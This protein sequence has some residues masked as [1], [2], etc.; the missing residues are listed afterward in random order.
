MN[1]FEVREIATSD[2]L[3]MILEK[4]YAQRKPSISYAFGLFN[5]DEM[6]GVCTFGKPASNSL[7]EGVCG[8]ENKE[9]VFELNRLYIDVNTKNIASYFVSRCL[10]HLKKFRL[11]IVS[12]SDTGMS[13]HGYVYQ[14]T[15]FI[16]TGATKE[17]TDMYTEGNKHS[18]HYGEENKHLRKVRTSK[19]IYVY[20]TDK[21]DKQYLKYKVLPYPKGDNRNYTPGDRQKTKVIN[22]DNNSYYYV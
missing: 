12:Y 21:K 8:K 6:V 16:Y 1:G 17:R 2:A 3:P 11:I 14:A 22:T 20:F 19:H 13:H 5:N 9:R 15:N 7:C 4:H 18:R 10:R